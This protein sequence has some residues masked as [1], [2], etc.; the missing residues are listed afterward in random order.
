MEKLKAKCLSQRIFLKKLNEFLGKNYPDVLNNAKGVLLSEK[1]C[2]GI[3]DA[4]CQSM[5]E[6]T[7]SAD[8]SDLYDD[9]VWAGL[10]T[11]DLSLTGAYTLPTSGIPVLIGTNNLREVFYIFISEDSKFRGYKSN[12]PTTSEPT[13]AEMDKEF[14][15]NISI[16]KYVSKK[17][18]KKIIIPNDPYTPNEILD[19][20]TMEMDSFNRLCT[21]TLTREIKAFNPAS[22]A[23]LE[24]DTNDSLYV[25]SLKMD[26]II[27]KLSLLYLLG[28]SKEGLLSGFSKGKISTGANPKIDDVEIIGSNTAKGVSYIEGRLRTLD[29]P[30]VY[31]FLYFNSKKKLNLYIPIRGNWI[32]TEYSSIYRRDFPIQDLSI[33]S[34]DYGINGLPSVL[35]TTVPDDVLREKIDSVVEAD[36]RIKLEQYDIVPSA[37]KN[38]CEGEFMSSLP[39]TATTTGTVETKATTQKQTTVSGT[40]I[41]ALPLSTLTSAIETLNTIKNIDEVGELVT[42]ITD[43][44]KIR[45]E[46]IKKNLVRNNYIGKIYKEFVPDHEGDFVIFKI[47]DYNFDLNEFSTDTIYV[48]STII[49]RDSRINVHLELDETTYKVIDRTLKG[50]NIILQKDESEFKKYND[51]FK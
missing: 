37:D 10:S 25:K 28:L 17:L 34:L 14:S 21:T 3:I 1:L 46:A 42:R 49:S 40:S 33:L 18:D 48:G 41:G 44:I 20:S 22:L 23:A 16:G 19:V 39:G 15:T 26:Q 8:F 7:I 9:L 51:Y 50:A 30:W 32:F 13:L 11:K 24:I 6:K 31:F 47:T 27:E 4:F 12:L 36:P 5:K 35:D 29:T 38:A 45:K 2:N 43:E